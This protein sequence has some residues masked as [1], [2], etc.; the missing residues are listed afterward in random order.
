[1]S[2][3]EFEEFVE[4]ETETQEDVFFGLEFEND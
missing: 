3:R 4:N 2:E 1:M